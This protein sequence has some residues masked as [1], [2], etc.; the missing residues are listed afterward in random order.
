[1]RV[2]HKE[3]E[4]NL[5]SQAKQAQLPHRPRDLCF[6]YKN[7][8]P[9]PSLNHRGFEQGWLEASVIERGG[10]KVISDQITLC[11]PIFDQLALCFV[12]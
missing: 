12:I 10:S 4:S 5:F 8:P 7:L 9:Q 3:G 6:F 11:L 2:K 1:M